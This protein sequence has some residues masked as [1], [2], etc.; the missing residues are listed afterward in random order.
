MHSFSYGLIY[1]DCN[2]KRLELQLDNNR[3]A[4]KTKK[5]N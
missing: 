4:H 1:D 5:I 2:W 3:I